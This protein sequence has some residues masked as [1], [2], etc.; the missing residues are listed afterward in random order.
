MFAKSYG[1]NHFISFSNVKMN[2]FSIIS[3]ANTLGLI[4]R[5]LKEEVYSKDALKEY[6]GEL[7]LILKVNIEETYML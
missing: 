5:R 2:L 7:L 3:E 1:Y 6:F 4:S